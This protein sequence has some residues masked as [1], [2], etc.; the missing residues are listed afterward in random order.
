MKMTTK[1][2]VT[3]PL[4]MRKLYRLDPR[5]EVVFE[6][7]K[8]GVLVRPATS[9]RKDFRRWLEKARGHANSKLSTDEIMLAT[10]GKD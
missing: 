10:R 1:G 2:Q 4:A 6:P 3:I 9:P 5:T 7:A 8:N